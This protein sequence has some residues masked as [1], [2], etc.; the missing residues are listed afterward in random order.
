MNKR[1]GGWI[2]LLV[3]LLGVVPQSG[4]QEGGANVVAAPSTLAQPPVA[5]ASAQSAAIPAPLSAV[6]AEKKDRTTFF[7]IGAVINITM[8]VV[9][10]FWAVRQWRLK[11][12]EG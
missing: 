8:F 4:G 5:E 7:I 3:M 12:R 1:S 9:F 10:L 2:L 6:P 11:N